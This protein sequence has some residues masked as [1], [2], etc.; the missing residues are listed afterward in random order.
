MEGAEN[1]QTFLLVSDMTS[2]VN[3]GARGASLALQE[4]LEGICGTLRTLPG[5]YAD[6]GQ[7]LIDPV[8]PEP[9]AKPLLYR[10][11]QNPLFDFYFRLEEMMGMS[12]DYVEPSP[13]ESAKNIVEH[14][15]KDG[16]AP[17]YQAVDDADEV[18]VDGDG[19]LIF[20]EHPGRIVRFNLSMI[21]L[22]RRLDTPVHYVNSIFS[23][24]PATGRN[25]S[26][27]ERAVAALRKCDTVSLRDPASVRL[28]ETEAPDLDVA[29]APDSLFHWYERSQD[30]PKNLPASG[31]YAVPYPRERPSRFGSIRFD[32]PYLCVSGGSRAAWN[33]EEAVAPYSRLVR[34][35]KHLDLSVYLTPGGS[36]DR[37]LYDVAEATDTP[38][39][40]AETP[41]R[42]A[43]AILSEAQAFVTG[44]YHPA[45][46]ASLGG[47]PCVFLGADSH[48]TRSLQDILGYEETRLF[49]AVPSAEEAKDIVE[50]IRRYLREGRPLRADIQ[51]ASR[52]AAERAR[53]VTDAIRGS[54]SL[55]P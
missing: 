8:L 28:A 18:V 42:M 1:D 55:S 51:S 19:D 44:R 10:R 48:K 4:M 11:G 6:E 31:D 20:R 7:V 52:T 29:Y 34:E 45:I 25:E 30:A 5:T 22:A 3:W 17:I 15:E 24:C 37:F 50:L 12:F 43:G 26:L 38:I 27:F 13:G 41:I 40:P 53:S 54:S 23:D 47:T 2:R 32:E 46:F 14:R 39:L 36:G 49:S 9:V 16:I 35:L 21:E 33:P